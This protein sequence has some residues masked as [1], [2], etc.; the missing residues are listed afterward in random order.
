M[1]DQN[2]HTKDVPQTAFELI[3]QVLFSSTVNVH[4]MTSDQ[5]VNKKAEHNFT[6]VNMNILL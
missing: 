5:D 1:V 3:M 2:C 4:S 6:G